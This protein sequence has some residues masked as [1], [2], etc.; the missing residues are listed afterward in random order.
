MS[1]QPYRRLAVISTRS[2]RALGRAC[3]TAMMCRACRGP[4]THSKATAVRQGAVCCGSR[5]TRALHSARGN[6]KARGNSSRAPQQ[7]PSYSRPWGNPPLRIWRKKGSALLRIA[8]GSACRADPSVRRKLNSIN[9]VRH[10]R[11][12]SLQAQGDFRGIARAGFILMPDKGASMVIYVA[13]SMPAQ[14]PVK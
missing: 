5:A 6:A 7:R 9:C 13:A 8:N 11:H 2:A 12:Y 4:T 3:C 1:R 14:R 10:G